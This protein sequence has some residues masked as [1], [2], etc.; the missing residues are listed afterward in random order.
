MF[1]FGP[2]EIDQAPVPTEGTFE[3]N[4]TVFPSQMVWVEPALEVVGEVVTVKVPFPMVGLFQIPPTDVV[5]CVLLAMAEYVEALSKKLGV[6][7]LFTKKLL[8]T[9][10]PALKLNALNRVML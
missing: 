1:V 3:V 8:L 5:D 9:P 4:V 7:I 10:A 2:E 6:I